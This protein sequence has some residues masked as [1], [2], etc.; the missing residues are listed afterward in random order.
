MSSYENR[1]AHLRQILQEVSPEQALHMVRQDDAVLL[2]VRDAD[3][4]KDGLPSVAQHLAR[5]QLELRI[6]HICDDKQRPIAVLCAGGLRSL[7]AVESLKNLGYENV[8]SV[9][10][11]Y[12]QWKESALEIRI[13]Q[14]LSTQAKERYARHLLVPE[15]GESG[16]LKLINSRVLLI[17]V[18]GLGSPA[19]LYLAAAGVGTIGIVDADVVESSNLQRQIIHGEDQLGKRKVDSAAAAIQRLNSMVKVQIHPHY[20]DE[21]NA[22]DILSQYDLVLDGSDNFKTRYLINDA[23][24]KL[25]IPNVHA[26]VY[27]FEGYV[28]TFGSDADAPCYRC[29]YPELPPPEMAPSCA[30]AGVL[31]VLPGV[32]GVMQAVEALKI[33]LGIGSNLVGKM[34]RYDALHNE[35]SILQLD[36][37]DDCLCGE[38]P[39]SIQLKPIEAFA[40]AL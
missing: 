29:I 24:V 3:E 34:M 8:Y 6:H 18:G 25:G 36:K 31:G 21:T 4:I 40:C 30:E 38:A 39:D 19:A 17:G 2:D 27:R 12:K 5:G 13:P 23:C 20:L 22:L 14:Q 37:V 35:V 7:F 1:A 16:Q 15:V 9:R 32:I 28:T 10:G 26:A 33:L 11:G